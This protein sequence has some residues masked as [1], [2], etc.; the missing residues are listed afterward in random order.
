MSD[1]DKEREARLAA[2][3]RANLKK[4]KNGEK[5]VIPDDAQ[6]RS[7][8]QSAEEPGFRIAPPARPE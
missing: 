1:K 7:G 5:P 2:A 8:T 4:R 3:L 6:R